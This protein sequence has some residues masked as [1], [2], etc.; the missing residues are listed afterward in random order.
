MLCATEVLFD[1]AVQGTVE[2]D[3]TGQHNVANALATLAAALTPQQKALIEKHEAR[4]EGRHGKGGH[5]H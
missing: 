2:W 4:N 5:Q 1:G 3:M